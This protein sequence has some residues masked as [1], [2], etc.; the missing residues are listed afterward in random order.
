GVHKR[1]GEPREGLGGWVSEDDI[2]QLV[3]LAEVL[4]PLRESRAALPLAECVRLLPSGRRAPVYHQLPELCATAPAD[5]KSKVR[6]LVAKELTDENPDGRDRAAA[7]AALPA[8]SVP[9]R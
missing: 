5:L 8:L 6:R 9:A 4:A 2:E 3:R 7:A 1:I